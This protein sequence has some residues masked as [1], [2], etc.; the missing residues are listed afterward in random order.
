MNDVLEQMLSVFA[1]KLGSILKPIHNAGLS[2]RQ[3]MRVFA[4]KLGSILKP[5]HNAET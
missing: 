1:I 4:I 3:A 2:T 5:I